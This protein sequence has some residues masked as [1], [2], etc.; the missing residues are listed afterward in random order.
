MNSR[1]KNQPCPFAAATLLL[2][3]TLLVALPAGAVVNTGA[4]VPTQ[5]ARGMLMLRGPA[6]ANSIPALRLR[7]DIDVSVTGSI[8]RVV[9]T[10]AFRNTSNQW[11]A[12]EY[13]YPLPDNGAVDSLKMVVGDRVIIGHI[14]KREKARKIYAKA[15]KQGRKASLV[16]Q[17]RPN[18]FTNRIANIGPG[19]TVLVVIE[20]Q[21][22]VQQASNTYSLRLPLVAAPRYVSPQSL[23]TPAD[24]DDARAVTAAPV[25]SPALG[26]AVNPVS[27]T[28]HLDPGFT[29]THISSSSHAI[30]IEKQG[31]RR[32]VRLAADTVPA[33]RDFTLKWQATSSAPSVGLF[34]QQ[35]RGEAYVMATL[36]P[37]RPDADTTAPPRNMIF[38]IDNSGSMG[39][40]S[41]REAKA[42]LLYA[43][44]T[45]RP[46]DRF[47]IIR[48]DD[49]LTQLFAQSVK[50]THDNIAIANQFT[51][52]LQA[53]GG[54]EMLPALKQALGANR[55]AAGDG[56][57]VIRQIIFLTDGAVSN[58]RQMLAAIGRDGGRS[59]IFPVGIGSAP[60][61]YLMSRM[62]SVGRGSYTHIAT[63]QQ[64]KKRMAQLLN[65][66][67][68]PAVRNLS[69]TASDAALELTP[70]QLP[71]L[72]AGET[73]TLLGR[74]DQLRGTL[75]VTG[76]IGDQRWSQ[77]IDLA[78]AQPGT[79]IAKLWAR[80]RIRELKTDGIL[81]D[82]NA[83]AADQ[84]IAAI[85][86]RY[87]LVTGQTSLVAVDETP[88][89]PDGEPL[90]REQLPINL[91]AG[92]DF[93]T[94]FG[95]HA[96]QSQ[97]RAAQSPRYQRVAESQALN[98]PQT[99]TNFAATIVQGLLL[100]AM[101]L[102]GLLVLG[103][104][105]S[106]TT[107]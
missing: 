15:A 105:R 62:A 24:V 89:R 35:V 2:L 20:Y 1:K 16:E 88:S 92:W 80:R 52:G 36:T 98:L 7:T 11:M 19:E 10:Q 107:A 3:V 42:S 59:R 93:D 6:I 51:C 13:L 87:A 38:V 60:N 106:R 96:A 9:V 83:Q 84:K 14:E 57:E 74:A 45:L 82:I 70:T 22:Q 94:L 30:Q 26:H 75:A 5:S 44:S 47:N 102:F 73:L 77:T 32:I 101:G 103:R 21:A 61:N 69:I 48:F 68:H 41:M 23:H 54:T 90:T 65:R 64:V 86:L 104:S 56:E 58:E 100:L 95:Q 78:D 17:Q 27:I 72:Y 18:L 8:Q 40:A 99:A 49:T 76:F 63:P 97:H 55:V 28:V 29:P 79:G 81:G 85:G 50:A 31:E 53:S 4:D 39:G 71:D 67:R 12:G 46:V 91:P 25:I 43:L 33:D 37:P 66:L 34:Y